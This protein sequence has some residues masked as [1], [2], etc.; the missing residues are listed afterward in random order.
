MPRL[1]ADVITVTEV[2]LS[3]GLRTKLKKLLVLYNERYQAVK[4]LKA[5]LKNDK[6]T[7]ETLF[8]DAN[9][10]AALE[11]GVRVHTSIGDVPM[12][13]VKGMTTR[14][15]NIPKVLKKLKATLADLEDCY[16]E[17]RPKKTYL[18]IYLPGSDE[19]DE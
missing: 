16:D 12:K 13:I 3:V 10:Y 5:T 11:E 15:L 9:E 18:A 2:S 6:E 14:R 7:L 17:P 4:T 8:A 19:E 1:S